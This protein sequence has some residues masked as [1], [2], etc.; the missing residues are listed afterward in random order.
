MPN[1][2]ATIP[3]DSADEAARLLAESYGTIVD[4]IIYSEFEGPIN[5]AQ[6]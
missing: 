3:A 4:R 1:L 2:R 5:L 6:L